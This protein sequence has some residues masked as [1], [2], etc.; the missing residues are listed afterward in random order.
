MV[1]P[2]PQEVPNVLAMRPFSDA[3]WH[4]LVGIAVRACLRQGQSLPLVAQSAQT[5]LD[6]CLLSL[7]FVEASAGLQL[8]ALVEEWSW[9]R[10]VSE[11]LAM[12][13]EVCQNGPPLH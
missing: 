13:P 9:N 1:L 12:N 4:L 10:I 11:L 8:E 6:E 2:S 7:R 3:E 5:T